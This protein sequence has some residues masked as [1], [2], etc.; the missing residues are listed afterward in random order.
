MLLGHHVW[1]DLNPIRNYIPKNVNQQNMCVERRVCAIFIDVA[2]Q[3][4]AICPTCKPL[5]TAIQTY[6]WGLTGSTFGRSGN[7]KS[8]GFLHNKEV[9]VTTNPLRE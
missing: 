7:V 3:D 6:V 2:P 5:T 4:Y 9:I 1:N 8:I